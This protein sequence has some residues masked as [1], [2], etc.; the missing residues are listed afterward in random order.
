M[1]L[2]LIPFDSSRPVID[3][4]SKVTYRLVEQTSATEKVK[5]ESRLV[6]KR[7]QKSAL[8]SEEQASGKSGENGHRGKNSAKYKQR[9]PE[10]SAEASSS[11]SGDVEGTPGTLDSDFE[12]YTRRQTQDHH[13]ETESLDEEQHQLDINV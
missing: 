7:H 3:T 6:G 9:Q 11:E 10:S 13:L 2:N 12:I 5:N 1:A 4:R 8:E